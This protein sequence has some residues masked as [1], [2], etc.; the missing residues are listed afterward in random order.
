M[1][2]SSF[3]CKFCGKVC[4]S[5][6]G[7][8]VHEIWCKSN[9][10]K[11]T[12]KQRDSKFDCVE[13]R[14]AGHYSHLY[15][16]TYKMWLEE[17]RDKL[18][19]SGVDNYEAYKLSLINTVR[20][21]IAV[22]E[23]AQ[24]AEGTWACPICGLHWKD[25]ASH[26]KC[27]H[28]LTWEEFVGQYNWKES[29]IYFSASYRKNLS[30]NKKHFYN[31][32]EAGRR[33]KERLSIK[34]SGQSNPACRHDVRVKISKSRQ[35]KK[36]SLSNKYKISKSTTGGLY[37]DNACSFGYTF[38]QVVDGKERRFRSKVEY[39]I[40]LMFEYYGIPF[41]YEPYKVEY[42]DPSYDYP[43]H[44][45]VDF[46]SGNRIFEVKPYESDID[47][48]GKYECIRNQ[49]SSV[50][51]QLEVLTPGNFCTLFSISDERLQLPS[52]FN[53]LILDNIRNGVCRMKLPNTSD[54]SSYTT[55]SF[56]RS[57]GED[58]K[59]VIEEGIVKYENSKSIRD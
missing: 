26:V 36:M 52:F 12:Y 43:K 25:M 34:Y 8:A 16:E 17:E 19:K 5:N 55:S 24:I 57:L 44:Y 39:T 2:S 10:N 22:D 54:D 41:E 48:D 45:I 46:V 13:M 1:N 51:K 14:M 20:R 27:A 15:G 59:L 38:W 21:I 32:T 56:L 35:G 4:T 30:E 9:P 11:R 6:S 29:K 7:L 23:P 3:T 53:D 49:L 37:S 31:E 42:I 40:F 18:L 47:T 28:K 50:G 33:E 58:P